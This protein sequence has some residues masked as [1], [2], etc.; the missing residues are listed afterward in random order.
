MARP[1]DDILIRRAAGGDGEAFAELI[2]RH[3][4]PLAAL[5]RRMAG[6]VHAADDVLQETLLLAWSHLGDLRDPAR[7]RPWLLG[8]ARNCCR[9]WYRSPQ[10]RDRPTGGE[11][12]AAHL[13]RYG[14]TVSRNGRAADAVDALRRV[15]RRERVAAELFYLKGLT[16]AEIA[17]RTR[18]P[19]GTVKRQFFSARQHMRRTLGADDRGKETRP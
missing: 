17:E 16:I 3:E 2:G 9:A 19:R 6:D 7:F 12:L 13:N 8:I 11:R 10:R 4:Q 5:I 14:R 15:P 1:T 18:R